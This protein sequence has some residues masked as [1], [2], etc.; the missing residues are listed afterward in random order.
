MYVTAFSFSEVAEN[1]F[2]GIKAKQDKPYDVSER[3]D[4]GS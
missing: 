2:K 4:L 3:P 1:P